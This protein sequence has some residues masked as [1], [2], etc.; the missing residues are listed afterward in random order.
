MN[1]TTPFD[2][3]HQWLG[4]SPKDQPPHYYRLLGVELYEENLDVIANAADQ[5]MAH[6]RTFQGGKHAAES[7][8]LLNEVAAARVCLLNPKTKSIYDAQLR[9]DREAR[10]PEPL[11][12]IVIQELPMVM[13]VTGPGKAKAKRSA[14]MTRKLWVIRIVMG[15]VV[16]IVPPLLV[17][18][19]SKLIT[20][21]TEKY[22]KMLESNR[23]ELAQRSKPQHEAKPHVKPEPKKEVVKLTPAITMP[24]APPF[25]PAMTRPVEPPAPIQVLPVLPAPKPVIAPPMPVVAPA[26]APVVAVVPKPATAPLSDK[27]KIVG[28]W[29]VKTKPNP[30]YS[31]SGSYTFYADG[32]VESTTGA[33]MAEGT[34]AVQG[35]V[36]EVK[37]KKIRSATEKFRLPIG[38]TVEVDSNVFKTGM[39]AV[40]K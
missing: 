2:A 36:I 25:P 40:R 4:I 24:A 11:D 39:T 13:D 31:W 26:P 32:R 1:A 6:L 34:W 30:A 38:D 35:N 8:Q 3:Y 27:Q 7:Q 5:R 10:A 15:L 9:G 20:S 16:L 29:D 12:T 17:G 37:W 33:G 14:A 28:Q 23:R 19:I 18:G 22:Q 21:D